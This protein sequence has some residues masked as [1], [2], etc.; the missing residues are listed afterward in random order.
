MKKRPMKLSRR[1]NTKKMN[2]GGWTDNLKN[3]L[4][5]G[6]PEHK[7][8]PGPGYDC[9]GVPMR[10][11]FI[12]SLPGNGG[13]PGLSGGGT[14]RKKG[15]R[16]NRSKKRGG[17]RGYTTGAAQ[18]LA[19][20]SGGR[21]GA[22]PELGPLNATNGVGASGYAPILRQPCESGTTN[23]LNPDMPMQVANTYVSSKGIAGWTQTAGG[24]KKQ[25]GGVQVGEADS[26][27]YYAPTAGYTNMPLAPP[28]LNN[29]GILMQLG[30]PA[31]SFNQACM[32]TH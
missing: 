29:P 18:E 25:K 8:Y 20:M 14:R 19:Q 21:W 15:K 32:N 1:R 31:R 26:M 7:M 16:G 5:A 17:A 11:G 12:G 24:K 13:L 2:G 4:Y 23:P 6:G 22:F 3:M 28:V 30:Y 9:P 27:R 10:P